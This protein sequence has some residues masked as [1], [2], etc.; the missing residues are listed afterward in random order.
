MDEY[1]SKNRERVNVIKKAWNAR[2]PEKRRAVNI[3]NSAVRAGK[4]VKGP[5]ER[6][7]EGECHGRIEKHHEDY[8]RPLEVRWL[9]SKHHAELRRQES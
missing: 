8:S 4:L 5:C 3:A 9:C 7:G 1:A 2:N 6:V